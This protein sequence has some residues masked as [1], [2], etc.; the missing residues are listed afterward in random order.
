MK[1]SELKALILECKQELAEEEVAQMVMENDGAYDDEQDDE[2]AEY[3]AEQAEHRESEKQDLIDELEEISKWL[4]DSITEFEHDELDEYD[5]A[6]RLERK[7][8]DFANGI[9]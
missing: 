7:A 1:K 6:K 4:E 3:E 9:M 8:R 2:D 5:I